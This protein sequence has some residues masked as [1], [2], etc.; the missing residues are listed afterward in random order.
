LW[1]AAKMVYAANRAGSDSAAAWSAGARSGK[2]FEDLKNQFELT[3][4]RGS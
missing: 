1:D 4:Y 2:E 3:F